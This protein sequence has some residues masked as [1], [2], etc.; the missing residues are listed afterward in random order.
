M[1]TKTIEG[2]EYPIADLPALSG[3]IYT[4]GIQFPTYAA[5]S[6]ATVQQLFSATALQRAL[7]YQVDTLASVYLQNDGHGRFTMTALPN[8]AQ[9]APVRG[10]I[11]YDVDGDGNLD[12][13]VVGNLYDEEPNTPRAD[14]GEGLW[15]R[16]DG[17]GHFTPAPAAE[18]GFRADGDV[19]GIALVKTPAGTAVLVANNGDSLQAFRIPHR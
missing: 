1:L 12:L 15:L 19:T 7:H 11:A 5:Y 17:H 4:V 16:G 8:L 3:A 14:A 6:T 2:R 10:I 13:M 9:I 18:S